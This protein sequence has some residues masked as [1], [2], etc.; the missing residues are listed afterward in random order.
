MALATPCQASL[1]AGSRPTPPPGFSKLR[2]NAKWSNGDPVTT[3]DFIYGMRRF[4][5]P[6]TASEYATTFGI[7]LVNGKEI[8]RRQEAHSPNSGVKA[9]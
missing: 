4:V 8:A 1:K 9:H 3:E 7:F 5:D 2:Q 6:K